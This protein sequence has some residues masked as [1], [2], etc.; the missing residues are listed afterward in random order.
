MFEMPNCRI[1]GRI[2]PTMTEQI[3]LVLGFK[4]CSAKACIS[5]GARSIK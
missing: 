5:E 4:P 3:E 1:F 2:M